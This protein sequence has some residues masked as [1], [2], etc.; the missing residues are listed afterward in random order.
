MSPP[1]YPKLSNIH[2]LFRSF[3]RNIPIIRK[4][5]TSNARF[6]LTFLAAI[7]FCTLLQR[8]NGNY[9]TKFAMTIISVITAAVLGWYAHLTSHS[10]DFTETY[11]Y[12]LK[13]SPILQTI[14]IHIPYIDSFFRTSCNSFDFHHKIHHDSTVN[15]QFLN[16]L[17]E[18]IQN[19]VTQGG[20]VAIILN[21]VSLNIHETAR[22]NSAVMVMYGLLY[23]TV[24][25]IN[26]NIS[27]SLCHQQHHQVGYEC[28]NLGIDFLDVVFD[29][30]Y[31]I[32]CIED[33]NHYAINVSVIC[34]GLY[35]I[36]KYAS[37]SSTVSTFLFGSNEKG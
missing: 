18:F 29:N 4:T 12:I 17:T 13:H 37:P 21:N 10:F 19:V 8:N 25:I 6:W 34:L 26:Y 32:T 2:T 36:H 35:M 27:P 23:A 1:P 15:R 11:E 16:L 22:F 20:G 33:V 3:N 9:D 31:D 28:S 14:T 24:H 30:K 7:I 5:I